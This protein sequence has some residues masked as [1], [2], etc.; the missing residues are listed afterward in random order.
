M[1]LRDRIDG[2]IAICVEVGPRHYHVVH[3][4]DG[5]TAM[6]RALK[7][8]GIADTVVSDMVTDLPRPQG[9]LFIPDETDER[10]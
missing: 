10:C 2:P 8:L 9:K 7:A 4:G 5:D 6:N 3:R 1:V